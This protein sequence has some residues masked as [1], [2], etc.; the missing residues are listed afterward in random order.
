MK[1]IVTVGH[2][3]LNITTMCPT[4]TM[5]LINLNDYPYTVPHP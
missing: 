1:H 2:I 5:C 4:V 3:V